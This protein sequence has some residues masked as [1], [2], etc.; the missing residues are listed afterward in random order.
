MAEANVV[1]TKANELILSQERITY[2]HCVR[3]DTSDAISLRN[4]HP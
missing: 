3:G 1:P 4:P 2:R